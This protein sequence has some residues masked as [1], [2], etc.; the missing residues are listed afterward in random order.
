MLGLGD[1]WT[2]ETGRAASVAALCQH[3]TSDCRGEA[4]GFP[5]RSTTQNLSAPGVASVVT[6]LVSVKC[7]QPSNIG[8]YMFQPQNYRHEAGKRERRRVR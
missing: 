5:I 8:K 1:G 6:E 3:G 7:Q 4:T 2:W